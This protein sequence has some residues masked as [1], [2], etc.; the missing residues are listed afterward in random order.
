MYHNSCVKQILNSPNHEIYWLKKQ[1][2][3]LFQCTELIFTN[4]NDLIHSIKTHCLLFLA[5]I[6]PHWSPIKNAIQPLTVQRNGITDCVWS[7]KY[8]HS[9]ENGENLNGPTGP[10]TYIC[11]AFEQLIFMIFLFVLKFLFNSNSTSQCAHRCAVFP[12]HC[13]PKAK[14]HGRIEYNIVGDFFA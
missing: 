2:N 12:L 3:L 13:G 8:F 7:Y 11:L 5:Q 10:S 14:F 1:F 9:Y 6:I 4:K